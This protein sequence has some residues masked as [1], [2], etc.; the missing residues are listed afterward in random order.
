ME[1]THTTSESKAKRLLKRREG[2]IAKGEI[3]GIY[4]DKVH[5]ADLAA[6][7]L[8]DYRVNGQKSLRKV[9]TYVKQLAEFFGAE[10]REIPSEEKDQRKDGRR[11]EISG[12]LRI[13][14]ITTAKIKEYI[15]QRM[16]AGLSN[17]SVN[18]ELAA[19]KRMFHLA[20]Q[21]TPPKLG[22]VPYIPMLKESN[23]RKGFFEH[24]EFT[25][26][27][28]ALPFHLKPVVTFA[29]YT[30]WRAGEILGLTWEKMDLK[31]GIVR[32]DPGEPKNK[33]ARTIYLNEELLKEIRILQ[34]NRAPGCPYVFHRDGQQIKRFTRAWKSACIHAG[35]S[36]PLKDDAGNIVKTRKGK[37]VEMPTKIFH[38]F[39]RTAVRNMIR[40]GIPERVAMTIS[41]HKT[42]SVFDRYNIVNQEDLK[43]AAKKQEAYVQN[44]AAVY[45]LVYSEDEK[46]FSGE[47]ANA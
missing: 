29:Y 45:S 6:D 15:D 18:R 36:E 23:T 41:G 17:A 20:A 5:F 14:E 39:R 3:P 22:Q 10:V 38:D 16:S 37:T 40:S 43:E 31:N 44:Q 25:A 28:G 24:N 46:G 21:C 30:G 8:T 1:S 12:G 26:L 7:L 34:A 33:E 9:E 27:R 42:R 47:A 35:L 19:L 32:L 4:F 2:E 13:T 11:F